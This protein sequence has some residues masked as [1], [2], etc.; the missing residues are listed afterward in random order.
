MAT[1]SYKSKKKAKNSVCA[2]NQQEK[3]LKLV[4]KSTLDSST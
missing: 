1:R 4:K 3:V 2:G